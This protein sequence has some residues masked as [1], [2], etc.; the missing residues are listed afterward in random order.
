VPYSG[1]HSALPFGSVRPSDTL[2]FWMWLWGVGRTLP[3][4]MLL[5]K[6]GRL[7]SSEAAVNVKGCVKLWNNCYVLSHMSLQEALFIYDDSI[8]MLSTI[9]NVKS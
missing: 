3:L 7:A 4:R 6:Q 1:E 9:A 5:A 8:T 2:N